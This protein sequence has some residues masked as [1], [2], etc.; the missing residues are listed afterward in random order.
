MGDN[1]P[2]GE[3]VLRDFLFQLQLLGND[4][5]A[6]EFQEG[7]EDN[8]KYILSGMGVHHIDL[9]YLD[10]KFKKYGEGHIRVMPNNI[11]SALWFIGVFPE[12]CETAFLTNSVIHGGLRYKFNRKT[13]RLSWEKIKE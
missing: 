8:T 7:I 13:K 10:F 5:S 6:D 2:F 3:N 4:I 11:V 9:Q 1:Y 12:N